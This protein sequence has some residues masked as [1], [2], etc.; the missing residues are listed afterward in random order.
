MCNP[1]THPSEDSQMLNSLLKSKL[2]SR[3]WGN[4]SSSLSSW[5][6][7]VPRLS[8]TPVMTGISGSTGWDSRLCW[9]VE[10][11]VSSASSSLWV[12]LSARASACRNSE[13]YQWATRG[14]SAT[15]HTHTCILK[16]VWSC[17]GQT[18]EHPQINAQSQTSLEQITLLSA[19]LTLFEL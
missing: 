13:G 17:R 16:Q 7:V 9:L 14:V 10:T 11:L 2:G 18:R 6:A 15:Q 5:S 1:S 3:S 8:S 4:S 19:L 12:E